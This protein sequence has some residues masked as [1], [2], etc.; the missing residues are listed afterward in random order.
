MESDVLHV[1]S[2]YQ[3]RIPAG[4]PSKVVVSGKNANQHS[5]ETK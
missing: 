1:V 4:A 2:P 3:K 5:G